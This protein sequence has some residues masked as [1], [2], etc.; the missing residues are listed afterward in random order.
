MFIRIDSNAIKDINIEIGTNTIK[1]ICGPRKTNNRTVP[2]NNQTDK[3]II[4]FSF[5]AIKPLYSN[6][7]LKIFFRTTKSNGIKDKIRRNTYIND[8]FLEKSQQ[9]NRLVTKREIFKNE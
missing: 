9:S 1:E 3:K 6:L 2:R 7:Y 8:T 5:S 4:S